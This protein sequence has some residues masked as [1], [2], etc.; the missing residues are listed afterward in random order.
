MSTVST[1]ISNI[2]TNF[3]KDPNA[4]V[5]SDATILSKLNEAQDIIES[6]LILPEMKSS[7]TID[8]VA[9][10]QEYSLAD[11]FVQM[12]LVRHQTDERVLKENSLLNIQKRDDGATGTPYEFYMWAGSI[13][14]YPIPSA[15]ASAGVKYWYIK[16]LGEMVESG[17]T[18]TQVTTSEIPERFHWVLER[19]AEMLCFQIVGDFDR[20]NQAEIKFR[21]GIQQMKGVYMMPTQNLDSR[22]MSDDDMRLDRD[23]LFDPYAS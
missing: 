22:I 18:G 17:A 19:G 6:E 5:I 16:T 12:V 8:L 11:D 10:T 14:F 7:S 3:K 23:F 1:Q 9:S 15:N 2:R 20:A 21:E 13:G 4:R